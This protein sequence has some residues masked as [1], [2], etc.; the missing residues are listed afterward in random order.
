MDAI[1]IQL[2]NGSCGNEQRWN[3]L[4][5]TRWQMNAALLPNFLSCAFGGGHRLEDKPIHLQTQSSWNQ[6][7]IQQIEEPLHE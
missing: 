3:A 2:L 6:N 5:S 1:G 4:S 7:S